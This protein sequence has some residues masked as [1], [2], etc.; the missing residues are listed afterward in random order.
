MS[1]N[2]GRKPSCSNCGRTT[3]LEIRTSRDET[4]FPGVRMIQVIECMRCGHVD[5]QKSAIELPRE[6]RP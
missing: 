5:K 2:K 4:V 1:Q 3:S 6:P